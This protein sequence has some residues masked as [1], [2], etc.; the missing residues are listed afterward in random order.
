MKHEEIRHKLSEFIDGAVT[1]H[2]KADIEQHLK[3]CSE[4]A[5]ALRELKKTIEHIHEIEEVESP[6]WM[7]QKIMARVREEQETK[8]S[9]W[10]RFFAPILQKFPVQAVAVLF[11][12]VTAYFIYIN[13]NP[14]QKYNEEPVGML[15]K[16]EGPAV[17]RMKEE[18]KTVREA[19]PKPDQAPQKPG[20]KSLDMKYEYEKPAAPVPAAPGA[21]ALATRDLPPA[22]AP[23]PAPGKGEAQ[24]YAQDKTDLEKRSASTGAAAPSLMAK[25]A[26]PAGGVALLSKQVYPEES[27]VKKTLSANRDADAQ[28]DIT[29]HFVK[30][31]LPERMKIKGLTYTI[32]KFEP[33]PADQVL[34]LEKSSP[35]FKLCSSKYVIDVDLSGQLSKYLYCYDKARITL[36][37][38]YEL[39][40]GT[41][42]E[43]K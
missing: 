25:Q 33:G 28:L 38:V 32:R 1:P 4:C 40:E 37:G 13:I 22:S 26:A 29:E 23:A 21:V 39:K 11:L 34:M 27:G 20:Y 35:R 17:G 24:S 12:A 18:D 16:K 14:A 15:A 30:F 19:A 36:L 41:W 43:I 2:E 7:T 9:V 31:D 8:N 6:A 42:S 3:T 5:D 10:Q